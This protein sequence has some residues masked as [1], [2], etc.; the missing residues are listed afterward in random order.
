MTRPATPG[1]VADL[2]SGS[3]G[4]PF[5]QLTEYAS[6]PLRGV[7]AMPTTGVT[8]VTPRACVVLWTS[9]GSLT[10]PTRGKS[11]AP[12]TATAPS[13]PSA[14]AALTL[15]A[16]RLLLAACVAAPFVRP[17]GHCPAPANPSSV[18]MPCQIASMRPAGIG[19]SVRPAKSSAGVISRRL[20]SP[21]ISQSF[22]CSVMAFFTWRVSS[23]AFMR[24]SSASR[25]SQRSAPA[26]SARTT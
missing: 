1:Q 17:G 24:V 11:S 20:T 2:A 13:V 5:V 19:T 18:E 25:S 26:S 9:L 3:A 7:H 8:A 4:P 22:A 10:A 14:V 12:M 21:Q 23:V 6:A 15:V 16:W